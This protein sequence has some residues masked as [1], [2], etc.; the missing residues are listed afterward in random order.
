MPSIFDSARQKELTGRLTMLRMALADLPVRS[1]GPSFLS[2]SLGRYLVIHVLPWPKGAPT[3]P[4]LLARCDVAQ[5]EVEKKLF[6]ELVAKVGS[7]KDATD[8]P[9]HPAFGPMKRSDWGALG[10]RHVHHHFTQFGI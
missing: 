9:E 7:R 6:G 1:K 5:F 2:S 8:W 4:E 3:A 10:Y